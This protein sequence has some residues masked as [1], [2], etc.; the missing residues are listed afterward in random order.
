MRHVGDV[1]HHTDALALG[2]FHATNEVLARWVQLARGNQ[3]TALLDGSIDPAQVRHA[4]RVGQAV[5]DLGDTHLARIVVHLLDA[6]VARRQGAV[7]AV[8]D[9]RRLDH[10]VDVQ[11]VQDVFIHLVGPRRTVVDL[12]N[13]VLLHLLHHLVE[14]VA[15][16]VVH[17]RARQIH[18]L[19][20]VRVAVRALLPAKTRLDKRPRHVAQE[21]QLLHLLRAV[22]KQVVAQYIPR[23]L[24]LLTLSALAVRALVVRPRTRK[25]RARHELFHRAFFSHILGRVH[26]GRLQSLQ[27]RPRLLILLLP[28]LRKRTQILR[29]YVL[30]DV[31]VR[32]HAQGA[33]QHK[34]LHGTFHARNGHEDTATQTVVLGREHHLDLLRGN[35]LGLR[36]GLYFGHPAPLRRALGL[37]HVDA[38]LRRALLAQYSLLRPLDHKVPAAVHRALLREVRSHHAVLLQDAETR[39]HHHGHLAYVY[40]RQPLHHAA[41]HIHALRVA[42]H[43]LDLQVHRH[44]GGIREVAQLRFMRE[45]R[46]RRAVVLVDLR[47]IEFQVLEGQL[48]LQSVQLVLRHVVVLRPD[49][50]RVEHL[51]RAVDLQRHEV[52]ERLQLVSH[53][54]ELVV[55]G[56]VRGNQ[57]ERLLLGEPVAKLPEYRARR[58]RC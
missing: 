46:L 27:Q 2:R 12:A 57:L 9:D 20:D 10:L 33:K 31:A 30:A 51:D 18:A 3:F 7:D 45:H 4:R 52:V 19:V 35:V 16:Q 15:E 17:Q 22:R 40:L 37:E 29:Q 21:D 5:Q 26:D 25:R 55:V 58:C 8:L 39:I 54:P 47:R 6:E 38:V 34:Q 24:L 1:L 32:T 14:V 41:L 44:R 43:V 13:D 48:D 36:H 42:D 11:V 56:E 50:H 49:R 53:Q 23:E 28:L